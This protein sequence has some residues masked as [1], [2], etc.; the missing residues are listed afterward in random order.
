MF[1]SLQH[2]QSKLSYAVTGNRVNRR[3][4]FKKLK[5]L[6]ISVKYLLYE[7]EKAPP[8]VW[9]KIKKET[10][11]EQHEKEMSKMKSCI[12]VLVR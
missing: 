1:K 9:G 7:H 4:G 2:S 10:E 8:W 5:R 6:E 12:F 3:A 11:H